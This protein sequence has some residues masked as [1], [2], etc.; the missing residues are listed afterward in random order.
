MIWQRLKINPLVLIK[1]T[2]ILSETYFL[3]IIISKN[4][5]VK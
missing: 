1:S 3:S 2:V 5:N 4:Y